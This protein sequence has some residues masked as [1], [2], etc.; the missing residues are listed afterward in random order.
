M[1]QKII[2]NN[3]GIEPEA[4]NESCDNTSHPAED[5]QAPEIYWLFYPYPFMPMIDYSPLVN[6]I[7]NQIKDGFK[8]ERN[9]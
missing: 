6:E 2:K 4:S 8:T 7:I 9:D 3:G 5:I 1:K